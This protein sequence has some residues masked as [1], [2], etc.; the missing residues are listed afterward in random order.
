MSGL[1]VLPAVCFGGFLLSD[2][3]PLQLIEISKI[4]KVT[5]TGSILNP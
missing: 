3:I 5:H 1:L 4:S 2:M